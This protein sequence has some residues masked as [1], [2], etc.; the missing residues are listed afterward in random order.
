MSRSNRPFQP[1]L[2]KARPMTT[3]IMVLGWSM[4][5]ES[6]M[7]HEVSADPG[8]LLRWPVKLLVPVGFF[9]LSLQGVSELIKRIAFLK[10]LVPDPLE[11]HVDAALEMIKD[12]IE[13]G[14]K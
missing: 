7:V 11:K 10:G 9:L 6:Y 3:F 4:F 5:K 8:G 2:R 1:Y 14:A 13:E 12:E